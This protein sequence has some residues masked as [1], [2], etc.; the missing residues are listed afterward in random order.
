MSN[1]SQAYILITAAYQASQR[2]GMHTRQV[3]V[4]ATSGSL[5]EMG[6]LF[7][8][9]YFVEKSLCLRLGRSSSIPD[10]DITIPLPGGS[11]GSGSSGMTYLL[12]AIRLASLSAKVY[13]KL[14]S[15]YSV[16]LADNVRR[17][18]VL[19][20]SQNLD[21]IDKTSRDAIVSFIFPTGSLL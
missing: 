19:E 1:P 21:D 10:F 13:E 7:W 20:L 8:G 3:G 17:Q 15:A 4:D 2:M 9:I 18:T 16:S 14:Y 6:L 12:Q 5:N 11:N